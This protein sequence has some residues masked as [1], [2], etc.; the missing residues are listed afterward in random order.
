MKKI[1]LT[2]IFLFSLL[3]L[4]SQS[5]VY[6]WARTTSGSGNGSGNSIALNG[7]GGVYSTGSFQDTIDFDPGT[8]IYNLVGQGNGA[9]Y[10][11]KLDV[12]GNFVWARSLG[13]TATSGIFGVYSRAIALD[14]MG[15]IYTTGNYLGTCD[16]DPGAGVYN[17][18][19]GVGGTQYISKLDPAG[20]FVWAKSFNGTA[21]AASI[22]HSITVDKDDNI[23]TTGYFQNGT[24]D[25]DP[26]SGTIN[27][28]PAGSSD[29]FI[30]KIDAS[31]NGIWAKNIGGSSAQAMG[32]CIKTDGLGNVYTTGNFFDGTIYADAFLL[33]N[34]GPDDVLIIKSD[35]LGNVVW[36]KKMSGA[37]DSRGYSLA[38]DSSGNVYTTGLFKITCDFDPGL[39]VQNMTAVG[40]YDIFISKLNSLGNYIWVKTIGG[41]S[42]DS[43]QSIALDSDD[44]VYTTG[45]FY[46]TVNFDPGTGISNLVATLY[47]NAFI[48]KL[49][50]SGS[51]IWAGNIGASSSS[52]G[53]NIGY[54]IALD[55]LSNVYTTGSFG[56]TCDFDP[57]VGTD[58]LSGSGIFV[59][60]M[61]QSFA[62][63][64]ENL[65][66]SNFLIY[67]NPSNN[68]INVETNL[69]DYSLSVFD[70]MGKLIYKEKTP[71]NK[72]RINISNFSN[73]IYFLQ[74]AN[75]DKI[76]SKKFIKE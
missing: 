71:Q 67:P 5:L 48:S 9:A 73:G 28:T 31:G 51:F 34:F 1:V 74:L 62:G 61:R 60:K 45:W 59:H 27:L 14:G 23:Y 3:C 7:Q 35:S 56:G 66:E 18:T 52:F 4:T 42:Y 38:V 68:Y 29:M 32:N 10:I 16:F 72:T 65:N 20:N 55:G 54:S 50:S 37:D 57:G 8:G 33:S 49:D 64:S 22:G 43:G 25:F 40:D 69:K 24:V 36:A 76:I 70:V 26:G 6:Q 19:A 2:V 58:S 63:I 12:S 47:N 75:G 15:N 53:S 30:S 39:G 44:N 46:D 17:L 41:S 11:S 21:F 13:G